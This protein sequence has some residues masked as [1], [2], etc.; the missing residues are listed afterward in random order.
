MSNEF[1]CIVL[2]FKFQPFAKRY[3]KNQNERSNVDENRW[4]YKCKKYSGSFLTHIRTIW[5]ATIT[6]ATPTLWSH[7]TVFF[8]SCVNI[9]TMC[10]SNIET[11]ARFAVESSSILNMK[12]DVGYVFVIGR[13]SV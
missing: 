4:M 13:G 1:P 6:H 7:Q 11:Y 8:F 5:V 10:A 3:A 12:S 2:E 9:K